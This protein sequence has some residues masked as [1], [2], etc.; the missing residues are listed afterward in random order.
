MPWYYG[1]AHVAIIG[2]SFEPL[3]G[4]NLIEACAI[5]VPVIV[6][7]HTQNFQQAVVDALH[8][9]AAQRVASP[10][11]A[12]QKALQWLDDPAGLSRMASAAEHWVLKHSGAVARVVAA[13]NDVRR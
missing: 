13:L 3:G 1:L 6:G 7:P 8:E 4:Q 12:L 5:G 10:E 2:G 11:A 9:G